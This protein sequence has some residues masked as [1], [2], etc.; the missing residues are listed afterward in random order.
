MH[1]SAL[2]NYICSFKI[3]ILKCVLHPYLTCPVGAIICR[4]CSTV[5]QEIFLLLELYRFASAVIFFWL[6]IFWN[7]FL[8][9]PRI[10]GTLITISCWMDTMKAASFSNYLKCVE[11]HKEQFIWKGRGGDNRLL[12]ELGMLIYILAFSYYLLHLQYLTGTLYHIH[13]IPVLIRNGCVQK[14]LNRTGKKLIFI[15]TQKIN[16]IYFKKL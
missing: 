5:L 7:I 13:F 2:H 14:V 9:L 11:C 6:N 15:S 10:T 16:K 3:T 8:M 1:P 4:I 12:R